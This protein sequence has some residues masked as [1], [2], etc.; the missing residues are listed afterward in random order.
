MRRRSRSRDS[1][2]LLCIVSCCENSHHLFAAKWKGRTES[3]LRGLQ[4]E[5]WIFGYPLSFFER[6]ERMRA[7]VRVSWHSNGDHLP[8]GAKL[9]HL[10]QVKVGKTRRPRRWANSS[11][12]RFNN[13]YFRAVESLSLRASMSARNSFHASCVDFLGSWDV[14]RFSISHSR[15]ILGLAASPGP[16]VIHVSPRRPV[17]R[18][19]KWAPAVAITSAFITPSAIFEMSS[20][21]CEHVVDLLPRY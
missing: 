2:S 21:G 11:I 18:Q 16:S 9:T 20:I 5:C 13:L 14:R 8:F 10:R 1:A 17:F 19:P 3:Y 15:M 12:W 7:T 4:I 6:S